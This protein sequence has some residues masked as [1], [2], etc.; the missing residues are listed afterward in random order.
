MRLVVIGGVLGSLVGCSGGSTTCGQAECASVC[1]SAAAATPPSAGVALS[2]YEQQVLA[3]AIDDVRQGVRPWNEQSIG[4]CKGQD[5][6]CAEFLGTTIADPLP[7]GEYMLRAEVRVPKVGEKG[8]WKMHL[9][10]ECTTTRA[11][12]TSQTTSTNANER[13][14][15]ELQYA[16]EEHGLRVSP[17]FRITSP[18]PTGAQACTWTLTTTNPD[19]PMTWSGAWSVPGKE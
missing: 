5:R 4:L 6:D 11:S 16:G 2:A 17:M 1:A 8:T 3:A 9:K 18:N 10:T 19:H 15:D 13:D 12:G 7:P 14:Y